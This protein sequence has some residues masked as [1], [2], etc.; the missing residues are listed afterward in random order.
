MNKVFLRRLTLRA[1]TLIILETCLISAAVVLSAWVRFGGDA[2]AFIQYEWFKWLLIPLVAQV[3]LYYADLYDLQVISDRREL[4]VRAVHAL[5][6]TSL[7]LAGIYYWFPDLVIGRGVFMLTAVCVI[8]LVLGWRIVFEWANRHVAPR[9][10]LLLVGTS[11]S[12]VKLAR[13]LFDRRNLGVDIVGFIDPDPAR[14][15]MPVLNPGVVGTIEDIPTVARALGVDRVVVSLADARGKLPMEKL[16]EMRLDGIAFDHLASVYEAYTGKIAVENLRPSWLIFAPG[17][18]KGRLLR[19]AKRLVDLGGAALGLLLSLPLSLL[20]IVAI[21]LDSPGPV[22]YRQRRVGQHGRVFMLY[23]F[24]SMRFDAESATGA[25]WAVRN[26]TR[27][28]RVGR[29]LRK[30]RID[31][32][33]QLWNVVRGDM[34]LVGPRPERPEFVADL[35]KD[36]P[37][38]GQRHMVK[39]GVTGWAQVSYAYADSVESTLEKLQYD[40]FYIKNLSV[41]LD[42]FILVKTVKTVLMGKGAQ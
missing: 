13:E 20:A 37:Y 7:I 18:A 15:G 16:L 22:F 30:S 27:I 9:E 33:P 21:R 14:V 41:L 34:S 8:S 29:I 11:D 42:V 36:I 32:L 6:A 35:V 2:I 25:V 26:D 10:K 12:A 38:Y 28:T 24:R 23:K 40:L 31:E 17:F 5:G 4:F 1:G 19:T 3:C 39:P